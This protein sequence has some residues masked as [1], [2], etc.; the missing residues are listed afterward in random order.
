M[1]TYD[2]LSKR[3]GVP[4][5]RLYVWKARGKLPDFDIEQGRHPARVVGWTE[6][7]IKQME[8]ANGGPGDSS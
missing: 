1:I 4:K 2:D 8:D 6:D 3:W 5:S 7:T